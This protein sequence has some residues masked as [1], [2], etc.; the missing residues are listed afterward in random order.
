ML[1]I[2]EMQVD[3]SASQAAAP[4]VGTAVPPG[5]LQPMQKVHWLGLRGGQVDDLFPTEKKHSSFYLVF[6]LPGIF[7]TNTVT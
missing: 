4:P 2:R 7:L 5:P 1:L 3:Y 6:P